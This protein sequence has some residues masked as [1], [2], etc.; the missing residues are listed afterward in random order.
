MRTDILD[1][2][3]K[4]KKL[5]INELISILLE[6]NKQIITFPL[7]ENWNDIGQKEQLIEFNLK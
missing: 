2:I 6:K 4:N 7:I 3:S 5:D 1:Y